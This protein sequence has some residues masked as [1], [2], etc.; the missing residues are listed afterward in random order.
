LNNLSSGESITQS[1]SA[2]DSSSR[3]GGQNAE[4]IVEDFEEGDGLVP[5][6]NFGSV[7]FTKCGCK[8]KRAD[9]GD[10]GG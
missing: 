7:L 10:Y 5:F 9:F 4:W 6:T 2:P 1:V 8:D 3:L